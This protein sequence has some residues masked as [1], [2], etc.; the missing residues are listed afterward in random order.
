MLFSLSQEIQSLKVMSN[1]GVF[2]TI[3]VK[4]FDNIYI[5]VPTPELLYCFEYAV[6]PVMKLIKEKMQ[7]IFILTDARKRLLQK[8][9]RQESVNSNEVL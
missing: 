3:I 6:T 2:N 9:T 8:L 4:T 5:F 7:A 1:G